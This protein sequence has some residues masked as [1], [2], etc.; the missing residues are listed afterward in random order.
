MGG[1]LLMKLT[2]IV[3]NLMIAVTAGVWILLTGLLVAYV[4]RY[5]RAT[6]E[7]DIH[8]ENQIIEGIK[9]ASLSHAHNWS[10]P[11]LITSLIM[12]VLMLLRKFYTRKL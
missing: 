1:V 3:L 8:G 6:I 12:I 11:V 2:L 4:S 7:L 9:A 5:I 10:P